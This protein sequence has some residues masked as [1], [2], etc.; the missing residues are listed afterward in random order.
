MTILRVTRREFIATLSS[1]A[2][3]PMVA[4]GQ[5]RANPPPIAY[6]TGASEPPNA[7]SD[8]FVQGLRDLDVIEGRDFR[9]TYR[10]SGGYRNRLPALAEELIGLS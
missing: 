9:I 1:A 10:G 3:W 4:R 5:Q 8:I 2:A 7:Y 6:L